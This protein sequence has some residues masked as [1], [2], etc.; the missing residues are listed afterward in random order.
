MFLRRR[1]LL[2]VIGCW[3]TLFFW[4]ER[5][6]LLQNYHVRRV[7]L[8]H[9][10]VSIPAHYA[11]DLDDFFA[12]LPQ[13]DTSFVG[14]ITIT[15][16]SATVSMADTPTTKCASVK[17]RGI[18]D[19]DPF[20]DFRTELDWIPNRTLVPWTQLNRT[21]PCILEPEGVNPFQG[22]RQRQHAKQV[23]RSQNPISN[24]M[25]NY[26]QIGLVAVYPFCKVCSCGSSLDSKRFIVI[27]DVT[28]NKGHLVH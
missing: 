25:C 2:A 21:A 8:G 20:H 15:D 5:H 4:I 14:A 26:Q 9:G 23:S 24:H 1:R 7:I 28:M 10:E 17:C 11:N 13:D 18:S 3:A 12:E 16:S 6:F 22:K 27:V 19:P